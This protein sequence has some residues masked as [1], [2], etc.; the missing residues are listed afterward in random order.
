MPSLKKLDLNAYTDISDGSWT[1]P[2]LALLEELSLT[3]ALFLENLPFQSLPSLRVLR[4]NQLPYLSSLRQVLTLPALEELHLSYIGPGQDRS[5]PRTLNSKKP[6][7]GQEAIR[8]HVEK[9]S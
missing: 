2:S 9:V 7:I 6:L 8:R 4:L 1:L 3:S 5:S